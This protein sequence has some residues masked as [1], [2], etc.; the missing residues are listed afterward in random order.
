MGGCPSRITDL[1]YRPLWGVSGVRPGFRARARWHKAVG[2]II[3][4]L[5]L[6]RLISAAFAALAR[7]GTLFDRVERNNARSKSIVAAKPLVIRCTHISDVVSNICY[8]A[9]MYHDRTEAIMPCLPWKKESF[10]KGKVGRD[11]GAD[12]ALQ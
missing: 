12:V 1:A 9:L 10:C 3:R 8:G 7:D 4:R 2:A 5:R 6:R 11:L